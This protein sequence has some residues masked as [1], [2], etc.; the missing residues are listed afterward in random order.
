MKNER[1]K[2]YRN[3]IWDEIEYF[4]AFSI[5]A[6]PRS[7]NSRADSLAVSASLLLPHPDF[8]MDVYRI[9]VV[10]RPNVLDNSDF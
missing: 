1:L 7:Q 8:G 3:R 9:E 5:E 4:D 10:Y 2:H 6:I